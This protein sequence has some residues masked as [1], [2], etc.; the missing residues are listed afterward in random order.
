[1]NVVNINSD[2]RFQ[3]GRQCAPSV[4]TKE[5]QPFRLDPINQCLWRVMGRA[6]E[7]I[8][9]KPKPF[10]VLQYLVDNPGRLVTQEELLDAVWPDT[11]VQPEV[12]KRHIFDIRDF[13]MEPPKI[14]TFRVYPEVEVSVDI[15][16]C[17]G[18]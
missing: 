16:A 18:A 1:M 10:A 5:F 3:T 8:L 6:E 15:V 2:P 14:L 11:H 13:G 17:D 12:L 7:R 9:L 4:K